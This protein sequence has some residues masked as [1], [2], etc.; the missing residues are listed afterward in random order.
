MAFWSGFKAALA[1]V[2]LLSPVEGVALAV[3]ISAAV[4]GGLAFGIRRRSR[5]VAILAL[6][7][8]IAERLLLGT[9]MAFPNLTLLAFGSL[10]LVN[11][12]RGTLAYHKFPP[13]PANIPTVEQSFQAFAK[14]PSKDEKSPDST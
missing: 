2:A 5:V 12:V 14:E 7:V 6:I 11:G 9:A 8:F 3:G 4:Y 10:L 13:L 1:L